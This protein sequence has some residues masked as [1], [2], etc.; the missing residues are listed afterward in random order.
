MS[1][2][3]KVLEQ[4][5]GVQVGKAKAPFL[6][7]KVERLAAR[8]GIKSPL[9]YVIQD[10]APNACAVGLSDDDTAVAV[11][12]GLLKH[13][14]EN[15]IE[16]VLAHE[17]GHIQKGHSVAKTQVA[18]KA[19]VI[20]AAASAGGQ[21]I[22]T[23]DMDFTPGDDDSDD[24]FSTLVKIALG[25]AVSAAGGAAASDMLSAAAFRTEFEADECGGSLSR[26]PWALASALRRIEELTMG[27]GKDYKPEVSQLFIVSPAYLHHQSH[28]PTEERIERL[29]AMKATLPKLANLPTIFCSSCGEKT[30]ADGK[31]C[32]WCGSE[33]DADTG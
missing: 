25:V 11:T 23:S 5:G 14:D 17:V 18:L 2:A 10:D 19:I 32:Y 9:V 20:S 7:T 27:G 29:S 8:A 28:P 24:L 22:A 13:L 15:E 33:L 16:A 30:D 21:L 4:L 3:A 26:R 12:T 31:Y 1:E 6:H